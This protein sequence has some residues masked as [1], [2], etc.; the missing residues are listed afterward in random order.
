MEHIAYCDKKAKE[1]DKIFDGSK[2]ML[3]RGAA[4]RK[5]PYGRVNKGEK[6]YLVENDGSCEIKASAVVKNVFNS[7]KM[8]KEE[9]ENL[10]QKNMDKL[11]LTTAQLKR[12]NGKRYLCLIEISD[13]KE[14]EPF[15]FTRTS[16]MDDWLILEN[17]DEVKE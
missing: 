8:T 3:I 10:I 13:L 14:I 17:I 5:I 9:S 15:K 2:T 16:N 1:L 6:I 7:E 11:N 4:G 12:W